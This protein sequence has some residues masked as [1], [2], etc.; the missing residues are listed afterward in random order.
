MRGNYRKEIS[1]WREKDRIK[2][3]RVIE[4]RKEKEG[5][6]E[7][8]EKEMIKSGWFEFVKVKEIRSGGKKLF[9]DLLG[10]FVGV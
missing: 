3:E 2:L 6:W 1:E 7:W 8:S 9:E 10:E 5:K 4:K